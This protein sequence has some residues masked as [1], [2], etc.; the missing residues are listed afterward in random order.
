M[1][2]LVR[3]AKADPGT[4]PHHGAFRHAPARQNSNY[5]HLNHVSDSVNLRLDCNF[6]QLTN[7]RTLGKRWAADSNGLHCPHITLINVRAY[8]Q[9][10]G[11]DARIREAPLARSVTPAQQ[12]RNSRSGSRTGHRSCPRRP[13]FHSH[14]DAV[15]GAC[16]WACRACQHCG[17][18]LL[19]LP[20]K[21]SF[22]GG[23]TH[24]T[25]CRVPLCTVPYTPF[26]LAFQGRKPEFGLRRRKNRWN[27]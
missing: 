25:P 4:K 5:G 3:L 21:L 6:G 18:F 9:N 22:R 11:A 26:R 12:T 16:S 23:W 27:P 19:G 14:S 1:L 8:E 17:R 20:Q 13:G 24:A 10:P 15:L 7:C 2:R